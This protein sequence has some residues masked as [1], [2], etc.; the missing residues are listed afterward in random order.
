MRFATVVLL[1]LVLGGCAT[2]EPMDK[3]YFQ[4]EPGN[5]PPPNIAQNTRPYALH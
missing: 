1:M 3:A 5:L 4:I 2:S